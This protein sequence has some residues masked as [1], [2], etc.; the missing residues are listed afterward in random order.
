M[1]KKLINILATSQHIREML[2]ARKITPKEAQEYLG[3]ESR[4]AVYKWLSLNCP[5]IPTT[6]DLVQLSLMMNCSI[7]DILV[8]TEEYFRKRPPKAIVCERCGSVIRGVGLPGPYRETI[9]LG[10][11]WQGF[12]RSY[13]K[14]PIVWQILK[15]WEDG[16][17]L[18]ISNE[19][20][21]CKYFDEDHTEN[22]MTWEKSSIRRWLNETFLKDAFSPKEQEAILLCKNVN[23]DND[24]YHTP[25][26]A[27]TEDKVFLLSVEEVSKY[28]FL[29][30]Y[31]SSSGTTATKYAIAQ[32][33][34]TSRG[35]TGDWWLRTPGFGTEGYTSSAACV[36]TM[37]RIRLQ[38]S[39]MMHA[40]YVG[41]R[42]AMILDGSKLL[43]GK[44]MQG[45]LE[46]ER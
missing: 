3:L 12:D 31:F 40:D 1:R 13:G 46:N 33:V 36:D 9:L 19:I 8:F 6:E 42:P 23:H 26:G 15:V 27:D 39:S 10:E 7:E 43:G 20:L 32:G 21:D 4:Q 35:N 37:G 41:V 45:G 2:E 16:R 38:G 44:M 28:F 25:G 22:Q 17:I 5:T 29:D 24:E 34:K 11:Y 18:V 14:S 30:D